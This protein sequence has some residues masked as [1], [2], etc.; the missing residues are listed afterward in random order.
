MSLKLVSIP[1]QGEPLDGLFYLPENRKPKAAILIFHGNCHNFYTCVPRF[2]PEVLVRHGY[3]CLAFNR[4]G[5]DMVTSLVGRE[6]TGGSFQLATEGIADNRSASDWLEERGFGNP[7]VI[8]HSN[9]GMLAAQHCAD[10]Y[11]KPRALVLMSA[12]RGGRELSKYSNADGLFAK[13]RHKEIT[14]GSRRW[15]PKAGGGS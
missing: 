1:S 2:M 12:H 15:W 7:I 10:D 5:H 6:V 13:D 8:G 3:A 14:R 11:G 4:R 9:G